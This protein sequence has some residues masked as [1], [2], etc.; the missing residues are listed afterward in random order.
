MGTLF[1]DAPELRKRAADVARRI[2]ECSNAPLALHAEELT[3]L[4]GEIDPAE[5]RTRWHLG[6]VAVR[7]A[8]TQKQRLRAAR[9]MEL[10]AGDGSNLVRCSAIEGLGVLAVAESSLRELAAETIERALRSGSKAE[11]CRAREAR[12]RLIRAAAWTGEGDT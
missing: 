11:Q 1:S 12:A 7:V 2:T 9:L 5:S 8:N 6:L 10:M 3:G 4:L